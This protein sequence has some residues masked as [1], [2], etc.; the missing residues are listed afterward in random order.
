MPTPKQVRYHYTRVMKCLSKLQQATYQA[1]DANVMSPDSSTSHLWEFK[2][3]FDKATEAQRALAF[4]RECL[5]G[6]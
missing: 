6:K 4:K 3:H 5:E 1:Q 2:D